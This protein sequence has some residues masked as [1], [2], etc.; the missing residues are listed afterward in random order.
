M[1]LTSTQQY[2]TK[3]Y[4]ASFLRA[5]DLGGLN[6]WSN[7]VQSGK[8]LQYV[9][10][11]IFSLPTITA[12]YPK[13]LSDYDFV[14]AIYG[15]VLGRTSDEEGLIYWSNELAALRQNFASQ[16]SILPQFEARAQVAMNMVNACLGTQDGTPGKAY[17]ENRLQVAE[18]AAEAQLASGQEIPVEAMLLLFQN[19]N[20]GYCSVQQGLYDIDSLIANQPVLLAHE[21]QLSSS[22]SGFVI[23][24]FGDVGYSL[25]QQ[26]D[27]KLT[28]AGVGN[29]QIALARYN[30]DGT[31]D[32]SFGGGDGVLTTSA[33]SY[34]ATLTVGRGLIQ[35]S[36]GKLTVVGD[37]H[38]SSTSYKHYSVLARYDLDGTPDTSFG[39]SDGRVDGLRVEER[40]IYGYEGRSLIQQADGKLV[41][42]G[43][44]NTGGGDL[45]ILERFNSD[46]SPDVSFNGGKVYTDFNPSI[47]SAYQSGQSLIQ[48]P[49]G[50]LLIAGYSNG[51]FALARYNVDGSLDT[52]FDNDGK[53]IT[54]FGN[55]EEGNSLILQTDGKILVAGTT[56][57]PIL[58]GGTGRN[59][60]IARYRIDGTLDSSFD[61]D[62]KLVTDFGGEDEGYSLI[63]QAD[64]KLVVA[65][66]SNGDFAL[67]RYNLNGSLDSSFDGDGKLITDMGWSET[68]YSLIQQADGKLVVAGDSSGNFAIARYNLD[69]SLDTSFGGSMDIYNPYNPLKFY[70]GLTITS[71]KSVTAGLYNKNGTPV[72]ST[73]VLEALKPGTLDA[74]AQA[75]VTKTALLLTDFSG[76][77]SHSIDV[78]LGTDNADAINL[79]SA[80]Y[81]Y[82]F[83]GDD[84]LTGGSGENTFVPG[85]GYDRLNLN[86]DSCKDR[87]LFETDIVELQQTLNGL[88]PIYGVD[89]I[90]GFTL[91]SSGDQLDFSGLG[92]EEM[93][94]KPSILEANPSSSLNISGQ[95]VRVVT[96]Y[97]DSFSAYW[98][99]QGDPLSDNGSLSNLDISA[100]T[101]ALILAAQTH[102]SESNFLYLVDRPVGGQIYVRKIGVFENVDIDNWTVENFAF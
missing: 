43:Q 73:L 100:G 86:S 69:G 88:V 90:S 2:F 18:Y 81:L 7:E 63:Q 13:D 78:T 65:G 61:G 80:G 37:A 17:L 84:T 36:D 96:S 71:N 1:P 89:T 94:F 16:G 34:G 25:I 48:Q 40:S 4:L 12:V 24:N 29:N 75:V 45:I 70:D 87:I 76:N 102:S 11:I 68:A 91:G 99:Y 47:Y 35:Q 60:A 52:T 93:L 57:D 6:Y 19:V 72:G 28:V 95:I 42:T 3:L 50:K 74:A 54:D 23:T 32:S 33:S 30:D 82:G 39:G 20:W 79:I 77:T 51:D 14:E 92:L 67:T 27:G 31:L 41:V 10:G 66:T 83:G 8:S 55:Y 15:N 21:A 26:A 5:P 64:G 58:D 53:L 56:D 59:F 101:N 85:A 9:G 49:N 44:V 98:G 62:G 46:G 97:P 22:G 38:D